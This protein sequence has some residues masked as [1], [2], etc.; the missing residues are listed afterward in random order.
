[1]KYS[2]EFKEAI[3]NLPSKEKDKLILRLLKKDLLLANRLFFELLSND[4]VEEK[5]D[6]LEIKLLTKINQGPDDEHHSVSYLKW[7]VRE[8]SGLINEHVSITKDKFGEAYLNLVM[9]NAVLSKYKNL[10]IIDG[11]PAKKRKFC[12]AVIA[13]VFKI[14]LIIHKLD[15]DLYIE[16]EDGLQTL[17][18]LIINNKYLMQEAIRNGLDINWLLNIDIPENIIEIHKEIR[19]NGFLK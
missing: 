19:T 3:T 17:G 12:V 2:K 7:D 4:S 5:R 8:F 15:K 6:K 1:M 9:I 16:F 11:P 14:L 13:R 10:I 18:N